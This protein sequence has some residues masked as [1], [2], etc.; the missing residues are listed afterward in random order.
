[1]LRKVTGYPATGFSEP[2]GRTSESLSAGSA[3]LVL[4]Q[5]CGAHHDRA[6]EDGD[7][8]AESGIPCWLLC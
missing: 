8:F 6:Q 1:M 4:L 7:A 2:S 5:P 3:L